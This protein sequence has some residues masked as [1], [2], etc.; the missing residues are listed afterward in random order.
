MPFDGWVTI[1]SDENFRSPKRVLSGINEILALS[2]PI[3]S[4]SPIEGGDVEVLTYENQSELIPRT[5]EALDRALELGFYS[6]HVALLSFRGRESSALTPF[7]QIGKHLLRS[8]IQGKY[9]EFG[10]P[11][12][13]LEDLETILRLSPVDALPEEGAPAI[14]IVARTSLNDMEVLPYE[15][16]KWITRLRGYPNPVENG[17]KKYLYIQDGEGHFVRGSLDMKQ[18]SED[19]SLLNNWLARV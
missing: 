9:D 3:A 13:K 19:F 14:F 6:K 16:V 15:S 18:K 10:N 8:P 11:R 7:T 5:V 4:S 1:R 2:P 12:E 17:A